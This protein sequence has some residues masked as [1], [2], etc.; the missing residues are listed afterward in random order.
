MRTLSSAE[1]PAEFPNKNNSNRKIESACPNPK[2][3]F[4][5]SPSHRDPRAL[6]FFLPSLARY[7]TNKASAEEREM[8]SPTVTIFLNFP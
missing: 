6:S 8:R 2:S 3:L 4:C 5:L 7:N 1:A